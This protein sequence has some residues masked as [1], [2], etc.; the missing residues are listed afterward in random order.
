MSVTVTVVLLKVALICAIA[1]VTLRRVLRRF[2]FATDLSLLQAERRSDCA[3][4]ELASRPTARSDPFAVRFW[5]GRGTF[6]AQNPKGKTVRSY[7]HRRMQM[8]ARP[9]PFAD[10]VEFTSAI[11]SARTTLSA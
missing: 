8:Q 9:F 11:R 6:G 10:A 5:R 1:T 2:V 3:T 4:A 7:G